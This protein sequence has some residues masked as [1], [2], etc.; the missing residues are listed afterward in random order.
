MEISAFGQFFSIKICFFNLVSDTSFQGSCSQPFS[1]WLTL[2]KITEILIHRWPSEASA[3][4]F[5]FK[6][7]T[8]HFYFLNSK[9]DFFQ[10]FSP[11]W[12]GLK[13]Y[14][15]II[16]QNKLADLWEFWFGLLLQIVTLFTPLNLPRPLKSFIWAFQWAFI[17]S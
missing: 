3:L 9:A 15:I 5:C 12:K 13:I 10:L 2:V 14:W 16:C 11:F 7:T 17:V 4:N 1:F 8:T 6:L